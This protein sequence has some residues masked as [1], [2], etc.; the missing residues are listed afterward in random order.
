MSGGML[1]DIINKSVYYK[2]R[3]C[4]I[5]KILKLNIKLMLNVAQLINP[6]QVHA[7]LSGESTGIIVLLVNRQD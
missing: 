5:W 4:V 7:G 2:G 3:V 6:P 1:N